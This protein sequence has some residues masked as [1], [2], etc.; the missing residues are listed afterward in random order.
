MRIQLIRRNVCA[1]LLACGMLLAGCAGGGNNSATPG[2][3]PTGP[4]ASPNPA[5]GNNGTPDEGFP[6]PYPAAY[7]EPTPST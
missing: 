4:A 1:L 6:A 5:G 2:A 7:P 3:Q